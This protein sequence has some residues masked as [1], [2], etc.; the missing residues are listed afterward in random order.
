VTNNTLRVGDPVRYSRTFRAT[1]PGVAGRSGVVTAAPTRGGKVTVRWSG[2]TESTCL[3]DNL[4]KIALAEH[5]STGDETMNEYKTR[6]AILRREGG[7]YVP[8][9]GGSKACLA[10]CGL[11]ESIDGAYLAEANVAAGRFG[12]VLLA[13]SP[14]A[15]DVAALWDAIHDLA[16]GTG[17]HVVA[18]DRVQ[19]LAE[20]G[21]DSDAALRV[22]GGSSSYHASLSSLAR[23]KGF[24]SLLDEDGT[25]SLS[26][27]K[28]SLDE[29]FG[30]DRPSWSL[31]T[32][33]RAS[34]RLYEA[35]SGEH[36]EG[37]VDGR[38]EETLSGYAF[39]A[40]HALGHEVRRRLTIGEA[41]LLLIANSEP[42]VEETCLSFMAGEED[43]RVEESVVM[44]ESKFTALCYE[45]PKTIK[46]EKKGFATG[47]LYLAPANASGRNVCPLASGLIAREYASRLERGAEIE[48][49][50]SAAE[51]DVKTARGDRKKGEV[52]EI[53]KILRR[54]ETQG[55][56]KHTA[57]T[58][59]NTIGCVGACLGIRSGKGVLTKV[60]QARERK[61][62]QIM[63]PETRPSLLQDIVKDIQRLVKLSDQK[64]MTPTVRLNGTSDLEWADPK[65]QVDDGEGGKKSIFDMFPDIAFYDYT[66]DA[67]RM[68]AFL[69]GRL[70]KNYN[71]TFSFS[72][73]NWKQCEEFL[74][75]GGTVAMAFRITKNDAKPKSV[76]GFKV[77]DG[78]ETDLRGLDDKGVI[79]GLSAKGQTGKYVT[80][81]IV[82][83]VG[84]PF[85]IKWPK[86]SRFAKLTKDEKDEVE[87]KAEKRYFDKTSLLG[88]RQVFRQ[89]V[90]DMV[91]ASRAYWTKHVEPA[92]AGLRAD[93][94][95]GS[96]TNVRD[97]YEDL[98]GL[99]D[100]AFAHFERKVDPGIVTVL[101]GRVTNPDDREYFTGRIVGAVRGTSPAPKHVKVEPTAKSETVREGAT[102]SEAGPGGL[103]TRFENTL[104]TLTRLREEPSGDES[105]IEL[106][107]HELKMARSLA[108]SLRSSDESWAKAA[109]PKLAE[110]I[111]APDEDGEIEAATFWKLLDAVAAAGE[112]PLAGTRRDRHHYVQDDKII[113]LYHGTDRESGDRMLKSG[114]SPRAKGS[115]RNGGSARYLYLTNEPENASWYADRTDDGVV[116]TVRVPYR[117]LLVDPEDGVGDV[118]DELTGPVPGNLVV[119]APLAASAFSEGPHS[120][121]TRDDF[122]VDEGTVP[123]G[124]GK[125]AV[126][127]KAV[128]PPCP[129]VGTVGRLVETD[130]GEFC[131]GVCFEAPFVDVEGSIWLESPTGGKEFVVKFRD[132]EVRIDE[133]AR[134]DEGTSLDPAY[135]TLPPLEQLAG[136]IIRVTIL[137]MR[138]SGRPKVDE[139]DFTF[140][141][142]LPGD[143]AADVRGVVLMAVERARE[144]GG[145]LDVEELRDDLVTTLLASHDVTP[146]VETISE[147]APPDAEIEKWIERVKPEFKKRYGDEHERVLYGAAWKKYKAKRRGRRSGK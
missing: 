54:A 34:T 50:V 5:E 81:F 49:L 107:E 99:A 7:T 102:L 66:K 33:G 18:Y 37:Y 136:D 12:R 51:E 73:Y 6:A 106:S 19:W 132:D 68:A 124:A 16:E 29:D 122:V 60:Q 125:K 1:V 112:S 137:C 22:T 143:V 10:E 88:A 113:T 8:V 103:R 17:D 74:G 58:W 147:S 65:F 105:K 21:P 97:Y 63:D 126:V 104:V 87:A 128:S 117:D 92:I 80:S 144:T 140:M 96:Y 94:R 70:P 44:T 3:R 111:E 39:V 91:V 45:S 32:K 129:S 35:I 116:L 30:R 42:M 14:R 69:A 64:G 123:R 83:P 52:E 9:D 24:L 93:L 101:K 23:R 120:P 48:E 119:T 26:F 86:G 20:H 133:T 71:L 79:V 53:L 46:G 134:I 11:P 76:N 121:G 145:C 36:M 110:L 4:E 100:H 135:N 90:S 130:E 59:L 38:V 28:L 25:A 85:D 141:F 41:G 82:S 57:M 55:A 98:A 62:R 77:I 118:E 2:G 15:E 138:E 61:T 139:I 72:G 108:T 109:A 27:A 127:L 95:D 13:E 40:E 43:E 75:Q 78:D 89:L 115:S 131:R 56:S 31:R 146:V 47:I 84:S 114:W 142:G 67:K